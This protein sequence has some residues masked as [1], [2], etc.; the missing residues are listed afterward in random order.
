M[1]PRIGRRAALAAFSLLLASPA[2]AQSGAPMESWAAI[3]AKARGQTV[4]FNAWG[5]DERTNSFIEWAGQR[6]LAESGVTVRHVKLRDTAEAVQRVVAEKAAGRTSGGTVDMIW[7]NGPNFLAM[8][9]Q[10]LHLGPFTQILPNFA[11]VDTEGKRS[12]VVDFTVPVDGLAA[13][14]RMAQVVYVYD[15]ARVAR[16]PRTIAAMLDWAKANP[17][18]L[19]HPQ[20]RNFLGST[21]LKQALY[22]MVEDAATLQRPATDA[23]FAQVTQPLWDWYD[24]LKPHLWRGGRQF[25]ENGPA[26]RT[27]MSDGEIDIM[28]SF[29]PSEASTSIANGLLPPT[30]RTYVLDGGTIGNTSFVSIPFN[31]ANK[32]G[33]LVFANFLMSPESQAKAQDPQLMGSPSVLALSRLTPEDRARFAAIRRGVATLPDDQL[34]RPL[35]EPHPSWMN[36]IT[37][38]WIKRYER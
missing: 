23:N 7:I 9:E 28:I 15:G 29:S 24:Q 32:E 36:R 34:G 33:A 14:W 27:L 3:Q 13:P 2:L 26:Q 37:E 17:G 5:G 19:T 1:T 16:P 4:F 25:P 18:R 38:E 21:F 10:G 8:K 20:I 22:A 11:L 31:A 30:V 35:L 12:T 6:V